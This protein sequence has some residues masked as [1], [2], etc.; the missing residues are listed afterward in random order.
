MD[1]GKTLK[2]HTEMLLDHQVIQTWNLLAAIQW[3]SCQWQ[4]LT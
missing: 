3:C 4:A 2:I 1:M